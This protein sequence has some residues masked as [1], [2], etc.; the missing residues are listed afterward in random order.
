MPG[1]MLEPASPAP[2]RGLE[3]LLADLGQGENGFM[4]TP[5]ATGEATLAEFLLRCGEQCQSGSL[6]AGRVPQTVFFMVADDGEAVGMVRM[7]HYLN[8]ALLH[9]GGHIGFYVRTDR[10]GRGYATRALRE[11]LV[12]LSDLGEPRALLTVDGDNPAS[13]HVIESAGGRRDPGDAPEAQTHRY[14]IELPP[15]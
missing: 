11:A 10:R 12:R 9:N 13:V 5:V 6:R 1:M 14:W 7:R 15:P 4:G 2:P 3:R 8:D